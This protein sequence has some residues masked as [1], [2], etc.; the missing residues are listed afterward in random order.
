[1]ISSALGVVNT[2]VFE[3]SDGL[4]SVNTT[5]RGTRS[6]QRSLQRSQQPVTLG[7]LVRRQHDLLAKMAGT[8]DESLLLVLGCGNC[9]LRLA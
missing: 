5:S 8:R 4:G 3:R 1:M 6:L 9:C 7:M 2:G